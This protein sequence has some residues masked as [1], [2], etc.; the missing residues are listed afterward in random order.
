MAVDQEQFKKAL[1]TW[2]SGVTVVTTETGS[3]PVGLTASAFSSVSAEPPLVLVCVNQSSESCDCIEEAGFFAVNILSTEQQDVSNKFASRKLKET[4]FQDLPMSTG[5]TGAPLLDESLTSID[6]TL[7]NTVVM[8]T[9][10]V[11]FGEV[12]QVVN[13]EG[14]PLMYYRGGYREIAGL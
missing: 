13:R 6:C 3:G 10:K 4:R 5:V 11:F 1:A 8:G 2:A 14:N 7:V 12:Q 9:H